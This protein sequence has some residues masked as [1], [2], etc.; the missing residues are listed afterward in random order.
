LRTASAGA[1]DEAAAT[2]AWAEQTYPGLFP[3][4]GQDGIYDV[5]SYRYYRAS[6]VYIGFSGNSIY[7]LAPNFGDAPVFVGQ[8]SSFRCQVHPQDC[9]PAAQLSAQQQAFEAVTRGAQTFAAF[10]VFQ[11]RLDGGN[12]GG[13]PGYFA[14]L[15]DRGLPASPSGE[16]A[17]VELSGG[18]SALSTNFYPMPASYS[19]CPTTLAGADLTVYQL[20]DV[21][22]DAGGNLAKYCRR[23]ASRIL[24]QGQDV[25]YRR[26]GANGEAV[27]TF[28]LSVSDVANISGQN[29][30][31]HIAASGAMPS[32]F[33]SRLRASAATYPAGSSA[34]T[35]MGRAMDDYLQ[36]VSFDSM[37]REPGSLVPVPMSAASGTPATKIEQ[38]LPWL[39]SNPEGRA[40]SVSSGSFI[41]FQ[42]R[43]AWVAALP[44][45]NASSSSYRAFVEIDNKVYTGFFTHAG[46]PN[47]Y[48]SLYINATAKA[49][50]Q[51]ANLSF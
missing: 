46:T 35:L 39:S 25:I 7:V 43:R 42:G 9:A 49:A 24:Y 51:A 5:Y 32:A 2:L 21:Y 10:N 3:S 34:V 45:S 11:A 1:T 48:Y 19:S 4:P 6:N 27:R 33:G 14:T 20:F 26:T 30:V 47:V 36:V 29:I 16:S 22:L 38:A 8:F 40:Y 50:V 31:G 37:Y 18:A 15:V 17:G 28:Q 44:V 23:Y 13:Q 12:V 41:N